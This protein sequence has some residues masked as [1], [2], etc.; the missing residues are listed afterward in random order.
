M[1]R[2]GRIGIALGLVLLAGRAAGLVI[3]D[4]VLI[5]EVSY[6][7]AEVPEEPFEFIEL[8]NAG[9]TTAYL[10]GAVLTDE[11][12]SGL[13]EATFVFPGVRG[14][15]LIALAPGAYL[16]LVGT[17]TGS[18]LPG[19]DFEFYAGAP[20][21]DDPNV[22]NLTRTSGMAVDL[23]LGNLGDGV[24]LSIGISTGNVIPCSEV[25]DGVSWE[26]NGATDVYATSDSVCSDP[27]SHPG[28]TN[29]AG[30]VLTLQRCSE[31]GDT[32]VSSAD[33]MVRPRTPDG[34]N[35]CPFAPPAL[36]GLSTSPCAPADGQVVAV[37]VH[38]VDPDS[39]LTSVQVL[40]HLSGA[41]TTDTLA[42]TAVDDSTFEAALPGFPD[43]SLVELWVEAVDA[44]GHGAVLPSG[45]PGT[46]HRY[47]VGLQ[48]IAW[49]QASAV[50]DSC[51][52][53]S[54]AGEPV[55]VVGVVTHAAGEF[56]SNVFYVQDG[57]GPASGILVV[58]PDGS[59]VPDLGDSVRVS[60]PV[61]ERDCQT[62]VGL[63]GGCATVLASGCAVPLRGLASLADVGLEE[64]ESMLV[65]V[66]GPMAIVAGWD[67]TQ[68]DVE[69][70]VE[71]SGSTAW[72]GDASRAPD[73][74]GCSLV[75]EAGM[76][77][78]AATGIVA[79]R[80]PTDPPRPEPH[81]RL[82]LEP[83]RDYD[84]DRD[85]TAVGDDGGAAAAAGSFGLQPGRPNPF[86]PGT[87]IEYAVAQP[88]RVRLVLYDARGARVRSLV[89]DDAHPAGGAT[90]AWDGRDDGGR[91][92]PS[93]LYFCRLEAGA[94]TSTRKLLLV[95]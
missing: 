93:G 66:P 36:S 8:F 85:Y 39:D 53:S 94:Q 2:A 20:D 57:D 45:A 54:H 86:R 27:G 77:L 65:T 70:Q 69:F 32:D 10:D 78:D 63:A 22:P 62:A 33:F 76:G 13:G 90:V 11:G 34:P 61:L 24:T 92:L 84:L 21:V 89:L 49:V 31:V 51:A 46:V 82:R 64:N 12:N 9:T 26:S 37:Q 17:A 3:G 55:T 44:L 14:D 50:P 15:T 42:M 4:R 52:P 75:P 60:G 72:V 43:Q 73:G 59:F 1:R 83:R 35:A 88:G 56:G 19:I 41:A 18:T 68:A 81:V 5:N 67:T 25:V 74:I 71:W 79:A 58:A 48:S 80:V 23:L 30:Q 16:T 40:Y 6:D 7:P 95:R 38:A 28:Y 91:S 87:R 29:A 47:R